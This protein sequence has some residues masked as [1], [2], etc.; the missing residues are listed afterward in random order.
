MTR[1]DTFLLIDAIVNDKL[2]ALKQR[3]CMQVVVE[4]EVYQSFYT[5]F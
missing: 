2:F 3:I 4:L 1:E 5:S